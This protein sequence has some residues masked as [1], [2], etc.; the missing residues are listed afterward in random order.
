[1]AVGETSGD[2]APAKV[3]SSSRRRSEATPVDPQT[4]AR[5]EAREEIATLVQD[6]PDEVARLLRGWMTERS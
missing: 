5:A 3:V 1:M 2:A 4:Q 6:N